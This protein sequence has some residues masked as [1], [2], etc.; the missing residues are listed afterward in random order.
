[1]T[2][3]DVGRGSTF[4]VRTPGGAVLYD[5]GG[6]GGNVGRDIIAPYLWHRGVTAIDAVVLSHSDADHTGALGDILDRF[7]VGCV[8]VS[9]YFGRGPDGAE[10]LEKV[11]RAGVQLVEARPGQLFR[12]AGI[13]F[14]VL[15]PATDEVFGKVLSDNDTSLV[16]RA[17]SF[18]APVLFTGDAES[19]E[20]AALLD[21][22]AKLD[23]E[24][25]I[26]PHHGSRNPF[27][28]ELVKRTGAKLAV[29]SGG[30]DQAK[31]AGE[32]RELGLQVLT[33]QENG[34][35]TLRHA[36]RRF[37]VEAFLGR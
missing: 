4:V 34:A 28:S 2:A 13:R 14:E 7:A 25:L 32:L 26:V 35:V 31:I 15:A 3:L 37:T 36:G 19:D 17:A 23:S 12:A 20:L 22:G 18:G 1:M 6:G 10:V 24:V 16:L 9:P 11:R 27:V 33:T 5:C 8:V 29:I 21:S 30:Y